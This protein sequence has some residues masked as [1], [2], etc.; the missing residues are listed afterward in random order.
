MI[1][2]KAERDRVIEHIRAMLN[3]SPYG[4]ESARTLQ[5]LYRRLYGANAKPLELL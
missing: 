1:A 3:E 5:A 4:S 2:D